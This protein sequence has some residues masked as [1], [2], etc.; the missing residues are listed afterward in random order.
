MRLVLCLAFY[1]T[2]V[3]TYGQQKG[4]GKAIFFDR[5]DSI[6]FEWT[7]YYDQKD[8]S[9]ATT[10]EFYLEHNKWALTVVHTKGIE[11]IDYR[12]EFQVKGER[13]IA[14]DDNKYLSDFTETIQHTRAIKGEDCAGCYQFEFKFVSAKEENIK[15][16]TVLNILGNLILKLDK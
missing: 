4:V 8:S 7:K 16:L 13:Y 15:A 3:I 9:F 14:I 2:S 12:L 1:I 5:E 6:S 10:Y 11:E